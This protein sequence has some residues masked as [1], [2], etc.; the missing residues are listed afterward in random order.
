MSRPLYLVILLALLVA[1]AL[2]VAAP[3]PAAAQ[4]CENSCDDERS[5]CQEEYCYWNY[6]SYMCSQGCD[7]QYYQCLCGWCD[8]AVDIRPYFIPSYPGW[9]TAKKEMLYASGGT[10]Y[11]RIFSYGTNKYEILKGATG[12]CAETW[13]VS[14]AGIYVTSEIGPCVLA[15][16][17]REFSGSGLFFMPAEVCPYLSTYR[18]G[19]QGERFV[20][21]ATCQYTGAST[22]GKQDKYLSRIDFA[23]GWNYGYNVGVVDSIIRVHTLDNNEVEKYWFGLNRGLLRWEHWSASGVLLNSAQQIG[24]IGNSPIQH[25]TCPQP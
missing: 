23:P 6:N 8:H 4:S 13:N 11:F 1:I 12:N 16:Q 2:V 10:D 9:D 3:T 21:A 7:V 25:N 18:G 5:F 20:D 24:E 19:H 17:P 14:L 15:S 22:P